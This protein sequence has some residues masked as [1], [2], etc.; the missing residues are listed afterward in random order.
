MALYSDTKKLVLI[1]RSFVFYYVGIISCVR[2][3]KLLLC[4]LKRAVMSF[5]GDFRARNYTL[6][7]YLLY[8]N[9]IMNSLRFLEIGVKKQSV[10]KFKYRLSLKFVY[11]TCFYPTINILF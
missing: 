11:N 5:M 2:F 7:F 3:I 9:G 1:N 8:V 6:T 4:K 10:T